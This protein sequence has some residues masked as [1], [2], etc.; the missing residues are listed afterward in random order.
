MEP[1]AIAAWIVTGY[2]PRFVSRFYEL[3]S[4]LLQEA[5]TLATEISWDRAAIFL[6]HHAAELAILRAVSN[7]RFEVLLQSY[8]YLRDEERGGFIGPRYHD[9]VLNAAKGITPAAKSPARKSP[10]SANEQCSKCYSTLHAGGYIKCPFKR[11]PTPQAKEAARIAQ[12]MIKDNGAAYDAAVA[13]GRLEAA[14]PT[15]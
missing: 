8:A 3:Y 11:L 5:M 10:E 9:K 6:T 7:N 12:Q 15:S 2:F 13:A 14:A 4:Q 1:S